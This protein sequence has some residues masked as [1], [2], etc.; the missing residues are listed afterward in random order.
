MIIEAMIFGAHK[1]GFTHGGGC[2][3]QGACDKDLN[4]YSIAQAHSWDFVPSVPPT[5]PDVS[6]TIALAGGGG[7]VLD[8]ITPLDGPLPPPYPFYVY[9]GTDDYVQ[10]TKV[11]SDAVT[12]YST[13]ATTIAIAYIGG[14]SAKV[15]EWDT[16]TSPGNITLTTGFAPAALINFQLW[17]WA[18]GS[19]GRYEIGTGL[20]GGA[21]S[22]PSANLRSCLY[23]SQS[24]TGWATSYSAGNSRVTGSET[25]YISATGPTTLTLTQ[26]TALGASNHSAALVIGGDAI[27]GKA[28]AYGLVDGS[29]PRQMVGGAGFTPDSAIFQMAAYAGYGDNI[30]FGVAGSHDM[31]MF[32][33]G[34]ASTRADFDYNAFTATSDFHTDYNFYQIGARSGLPNV[35]WIV[36][37][38]YSNGLYMNYDLNGDGVHDTP[39]SGTGNSHVLY[40]GL[41]DVVEPNGSLPILGVG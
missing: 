25:I 27:Q 35:K 14:C 40:L 32:S 1:G 26:A 33:L 8:L 34:V 29:I 22:A 24:A 9:R 36:D 28:V 20:W 4:Q 2:V 21:L 31:G 30:S 6:S 12:L 16:L 41:K 10:V 11:D 13:I 37:E 19:Y 17:E 5:L 18:S 3:S 23:L 39:L 15:I 7:R 38:Y